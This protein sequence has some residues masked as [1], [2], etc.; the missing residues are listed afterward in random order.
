[1]INT[2]DNTENILRNYLTE[3]EVAF[4]DDAVIKILTLWDEIYNFN[5]TTNIVGSKEKDEIFTRHILDCLSIFNLKNDF[6]QDFLTGKKILDLG[7]GAGL[8]GLL[9]SILLS[10]SQI[11]LLEKHQ[12]KV[13]FL[14]KM[15]DLLEIKNTVVL[16][17][18]AEY[19][20]KDKNYRGIFDICVGRAVSKINIL[21]ELI[22]P[23]CKIDG[24]ILL[25]KSRKVFL[26][27]EENMVK[28]ER[29]GAKINKIEEIKVPF[30]EE[31]RAILIL[32]KKAKTPDKYPRDFSIIKKEK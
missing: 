7:T 16:D 11:V 4:N 17:T 15:I 22:I 5:I 1:M 14:L 26:E 23:F 24:K 2:N 9:F 30:L 21:L 27:A 32:D 29:L 3:M 25:Y 12:K 10:N 18:P 28:L 6:N 31:F 19:L 13:N 20:G 8:P